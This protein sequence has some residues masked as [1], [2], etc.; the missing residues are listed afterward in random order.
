MGFAV[1]Y[2]IVD[3]DYMIETK[4]KVEDMIS[5]IQNA[6]KRIIKLS[7]MDRQSKE[8]SLRKLEK[9]ISLIGFP[10]WILDKSELERQYK[11]VSVY[12]YLLYIRNQI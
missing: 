10:E 9:T 11:G 12:G 1:S 4:P 6:F 7:W 5:N 3:K 8:K 2:L